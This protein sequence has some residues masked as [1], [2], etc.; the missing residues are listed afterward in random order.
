M[1]AGFR[2]TL[3]VC[4]LFATA[5]SAFAS[6]S[7]CPADPIEGSDTLLTI[8]NQFSQFNITNIRMIGPG[9]TLPSD[10]ILSGAIPSGTSVEIVLSGPERETNPDGVV[11]TALVGG[12]LDR[13]VKQSNPS[14]L[15]PA[16]NA[17]FNDLDTDNNDALTLTEV[18]AGY[19]DFTQFN[20][21]TFDLN[22]SG[23]IELNETGALL[24]FATAT[25]TCVHNGDQIVWNFDGA[26]PADACADAR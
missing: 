14:E 10:N 6:L 11:W 15:R 23:K 5:A 22:N 7:G 17:D 26:S 16:L 1:T 8:N 2:R 24:R 25:F 9:D 12:L 19:P 3:R 4:V 18:Q 13:R 21:D 20:L